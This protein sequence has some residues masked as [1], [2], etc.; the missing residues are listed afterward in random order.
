MPRL[1]GHT[2][3]CFRN[4][5]SSRGRQRMRCSGWPA[6][7]S[8]EFD[9]LTI[10]GWGALRSRRSEKRSSGS[11][12]GSAGS[13]GRQ[14]GLTHRERFVQRWPRPKV[15]GDPATRSEG[16]TPHGEAART[17]SRWPRN[18]RPCPAVG[19]LV[20]K[21]PHRWQF[22]RATASTKRP[23]FRT[24]PPRRKGL[25]RLRATRRKPQPEDHRR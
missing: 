22:R 4:G 21:R 20:P 9:M 25:D 19:E 5:V 2:E 13:G 8:L 18:S 10:L 17:S 12:W 24:Q 14:I 16:C 15:A 11:S 23:P 6:G 3:A 1:S 7:L